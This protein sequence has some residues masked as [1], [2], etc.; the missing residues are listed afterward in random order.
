MMA[1]TTWRGRGLGT[2]VVVFVDELGADV[3]PGRRDVLPCP[4]AA[5]QSA[6]AGRPDGPYRG[7][8]RLHRERGGTLRGARPCLADG[9]RAVPLRGHEHRGCHR[10]PQ[11]AREP[12][13]CCHRHPGRRPRGVG[14][15]G[16]LGSM[17][18][19]EQID[20]MRA[21]G[22]NDIK[23]LVLAGCPDD[24]C[25]APSDHHRQYPGRLRRH[26][27]LAVRI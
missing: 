15:H 24:D 16:G 27:D 11:H 25:P 5:L 14:V 10:G 12:Q 4:D 9:V 1:S 8:F 18:V 13:P 3:R 7:A 17:R 23:R 2:R 20:A 6:V 26:G 19:T 22:V 21:L